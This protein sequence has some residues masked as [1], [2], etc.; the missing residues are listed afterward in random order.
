MEVHCGFSLVGRYTL[1]VFYK[2]AYAPDA[3]KQINT[4]SYG[5][6]PEFITIEPNLG[7]VHRLRPISL[8]AKLG[9]LHV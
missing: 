7:G 8:P 4:Q 3:Y 2:N 9:F 5:I 1:P 6:K